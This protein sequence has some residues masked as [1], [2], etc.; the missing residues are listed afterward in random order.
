MA[1]P[2][3]TRGSCIAIAVRYPPAE[4]PATNTRAASPPCSL[5]WSIVHATAAR[6]S[7][8]IAS[9]R[10]AGAS[11]YSTRTRLKPAGR[12]ASPTYESGSLSLLC[13]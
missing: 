2:P 6:T 3:A 4:L 7:A 11:V 1:S 5:A 8:T 13:Q 10:A 9:S 12:S